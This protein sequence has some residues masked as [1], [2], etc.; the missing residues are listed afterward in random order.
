MSQEHRSQEHRSQDP[1]GPHLD[2]LSFFDLDLVVGNF[3]LDLVVGD[4]V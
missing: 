1:T 2:Q 3:D 4:L